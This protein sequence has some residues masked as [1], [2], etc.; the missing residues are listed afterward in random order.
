MLFY[1]LLTNPG[2]N[3]IRMRSVAVIF[4]V[5]VAVIVAASEAKPVEVEEVVWPAYMSFV[6]ERE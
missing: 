4:V 2:L 5:V 3:S 1:T 6:F